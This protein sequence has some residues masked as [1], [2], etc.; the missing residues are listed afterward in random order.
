[1]RRNGFVYMVCHLREQSAREM[2]L[3]MATVEIGARGEPTHILRLLKHAEE[4]ARGADDVARIVRVCSLR[5]VT[6]HS[7]FS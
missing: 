4:G 7:G 6:A 3:V 1:M 2:Y 5:D